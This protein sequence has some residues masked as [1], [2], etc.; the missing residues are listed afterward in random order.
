MQSMLAMQI[1]DLDDIS[2][3]SLTL[4]LATARAII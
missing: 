3:K 2:M 4:H 1:S